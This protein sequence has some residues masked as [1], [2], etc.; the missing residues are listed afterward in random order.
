MHRFQPYVNFI[1]I[2]ED[3]SKSNL[4][5]TVTTKKRSKIVSIR[6]G[7]LNSNIKLEVT[8]SKKK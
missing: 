7:E 4:K 1:K 5:K 3:M 8:W 6:P 2:L